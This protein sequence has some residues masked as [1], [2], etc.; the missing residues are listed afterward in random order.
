MSTVL[1]QLS[2]LR[3]SDTSDEGHR[4]Y[5][6]LHLTFQ[7]YFAAQYYVEHWKSGKP[8][9]YLKFSN[10]KARLES[11]L[12]ESFLQREKYNILYDVLWRFVTGMLQGQDEDHLRRFF[13]L[14][15]DEPR[16]LLG[17]VHQRL[18]VHCL[19][20]V[21]SSNKTSTSISLRENLE[22]QLSRWALSEY[23][24]NGT[25]TLAGDMQF[26]QSVLEAI[27]EEGSEDQTLS[28]MRLLSDR[29]TCLPSFIKFMTAWL[30]GDVS[31]RMM[32]SIC[33]KLNAQH[34]NLPDETLNALARRLGD[35]HYS[36]RC[37]ALGVLHRQRTLPEAILE[38]VAERLEDN[39][40]RVRAAAAFALSGTLDPTIELLKAFMVRSVYSADSN[41][42]GICSHILGIK[43]TSLKEALEAI[44][45]EEFLEE[46]L[47]T[48]VLEAEA[49]PALKKGFVEEILP[50]ELL[51]LMA[52]FLLLKEGVK[53]TW[54]E[55]LL[56]A[57]AKP[58]LSGDI[59]AA[60]EKR[61][62]D[63]NDEVWKAATNA[64]CLH[65]VLP[66]EI[67]ERVAKRL[68]DTESNVRQAAARILG[69]QA[70]LPRGILRIMV[71]QLD[72]EDSIVKIATVHALG[73]QYNLPEE[74]L[75]AVAKRLGDPDSNVSQAV[76]NILV[77]QPNFLRVFMLFQ[78]KKLRREELRE[79]SLNVSP[80]GPLASVVAELDDP[81]S[82][83][84]EIIR[85]AW[86]YQST[87]PLEILTA[88][89]ENLNHEDSRT[90][91]AILRALIG[92]SNLPEEIV[93]TVA[94]LLT[95]GNLEVR[96]A[97]ARVLEQ[98][99]ALSEEIGQALAVVM[100]DQKD[101]EET[102][103]RGTYTGTSSN[104]EDE[105]SSLLLVTWLRD[106]DSSFIPSTR[107]LNTW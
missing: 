24:S 19:S 78:L 83:V 70:A 30:N 103:Y 106:F 1:A 41:L 48:K 98:Q 26:P 22:E 80:D 101:R 37:S 92:Q 3:T 64:L 25:A 60:L 2:L 15:E 13:A 28:L 82:G 69:D 84:K 61:L 100:D 9:P 5:H 71:E 35:Q 46:T 10:G 77:F 94:A 6:F 42:A 72:D 90:R 12:P 88:M 86:T 8:L 18:V 99:S 32:A 59:L 40:S 43:W 55:E 4:S 56:D 74:I 66:V 16:D 49:T 54:P 31:P 47:P 105:F 62:D 34:R 53:E 29:R 27:L 39:D 33:E 87:L 44:L 76:A 57:L 85:S 17:L 36:I 96:D 38:D 23:D 107:L 63:E 75:K 58:P 79:L 11:I 65:S 52:E 14:I 102:N 45:S 97:A 81:D 20:E 67:L 104:T 68:D 7:A 21:D 89:A 95:D 93:T 51:R 73:S 91:K 50:G